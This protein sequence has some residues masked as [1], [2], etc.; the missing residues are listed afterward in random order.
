FELLNDALNI[1]NIDFGRD[2]YA[3]YGKMMQEKGFEEQALQAYIIAADRNCQDPG[4]YRYLAQ[5]A[6]EKGMNE[7]ALIMAKNAL[8]LDK[9]DLDNYLLIYKLYSILNKKE[10]ESV[11]RIV[12][13]IYPEIDLAELLAIYQQNN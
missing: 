9:A 11:N 3:R 2:D 7:D 5:K 10:A 8:N 1:Y 6:A 13:G 12:K 4:V